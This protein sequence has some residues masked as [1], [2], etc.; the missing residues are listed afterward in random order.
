[1]HILATWASIFAGAERPSASRRG[2]RKAAFDAWEEGV[3]LQ[4][5]FSGTVEKVGVTSE[6]FTETSKWIFLSEP[7]VLSQVLG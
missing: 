1:M 4:D 2:R 5:N 6:A 3:T 7:K